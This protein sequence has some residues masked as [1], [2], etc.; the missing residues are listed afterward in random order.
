MRTTTAYAVMRRD[1]AQALAVFVSAEHATAFAAQ[2]NQLVP[3]AEAFDTSKHALWAVYPW[4][5]A[6]DFFNAEG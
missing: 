2:L 6:A 3:F 5:A 4:T 1:D